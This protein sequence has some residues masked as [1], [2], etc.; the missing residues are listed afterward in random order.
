MNVL[1][2]A[3]GALLEQQVGTELPP[4]IQ[5]NGQNLVRYPHGVLDTRSQQIIPVYAPEPLNKNADQLD[6]LL[7]GTRFKRT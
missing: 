5:V 1:L 2:I 6:A 3:N 7:E 4:S